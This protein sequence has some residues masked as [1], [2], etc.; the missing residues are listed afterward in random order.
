MH[1][2]ALFWNFTKAHVKGFFSES[3]NPQGQEKSEMR[4]EKLTLEAEK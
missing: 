4:Q 1:A 2:S 3:I